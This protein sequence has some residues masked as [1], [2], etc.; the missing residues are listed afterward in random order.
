[1]TT[2]D[3]LGAT[4]ILSEGEC[5]ERLSARS[6]GR[7]AVIL[8]GRVEIFTVN[9][10]LD[11]EG[12]IFRSNA[13]RKM[14]GAW[15]REVTFEVDSVD[16]EA[17]TGWSVVIHGPARDITRF[18]APMRQIAARSWTGPKDFLVRIAPRS[19]SGRRLAFNP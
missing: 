5:W 12:V 19:L 18:D 9:Y 17:G 2:I 11:G 7:L 13:G 16:T 3:L 1:M 14:C 4:G 10:G 8:D 15:N 6:V